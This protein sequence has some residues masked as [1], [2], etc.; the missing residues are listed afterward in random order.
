L[1]LPVPPFAVPVHVPCVSQAMVLDPTVLDILITAAGEN[2]VP[3]M[4]RVE[5]TVPDV[6]AV[7]TPPDIVDRDTEAVAACALLSGSRNT[8]PVIPARNNSPIVPKEASLSG[9]C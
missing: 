5:P 7:F 2:P 1:A 4:T 8:I 6:A 3:V 9:C